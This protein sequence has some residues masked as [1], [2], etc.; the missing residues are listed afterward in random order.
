M[1]KLPINSKDIHIRASAQALK[2]YF[3]ENAAPLV[4]QYIDAALGVAEIQSTNATAREEVWDVL[5]QLM[6]QSSD[7]LEI[8]IE[9]ADDILTA[10]SQGKCTFEE[11]EKLLSLYKKLKEV[12]EVALIPGTTEQ[13]GLTI[14]IL[15]AQP[16]VI[17]QDTTLPIEHDP[18][19]IAPLTVEIPDDSEN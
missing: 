13:A 19:I 12:N 16:A 17:A 14:N 4:K 7:K 1:A 15:Q 2:Q 6:L 5:K 18:T 10:V 9:K 8:S 3:L 11:G